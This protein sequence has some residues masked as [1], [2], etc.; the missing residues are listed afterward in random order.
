MIE[1]RGTVVAAAPG[2]ARVRTERSGACDGCAARGACSH[3]GGGREAEVWALDPV[4]VAEGDRVVIAVPESTVVRA[5]VVVYLVPV[6]AL[7]AGAALGSHLGPRYG[8]SAD[9]AAAGLGLA[10]MGAAL[11]ASRL[12]ARPGDQPR[13]VRRA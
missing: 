12:F 3:L 1:E 6:L 10:A 5:S 9:L 11:L 2:R 4:G 13:I 8:F 7:V